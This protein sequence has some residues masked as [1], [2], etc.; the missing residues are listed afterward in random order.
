MMTAGYLLFTLPQSG[1]S[2]IASRLITALIQITIVVL[3]SFLMF[4][5]NIPDEI[6]LEF[7]FKDLKLN[8]I[9]Y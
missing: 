2:I 6:S 1:V 4:Y 8:V 9:L 5:F 7:F 3:V